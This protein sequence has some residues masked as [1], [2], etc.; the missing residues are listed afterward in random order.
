MEVQ[1]PV[2]NYE[3]ADYWLDCLLLSDGLKASSVC[4]GCNTDTKMWLES[5]FEG[6]RAE[7]HVVNEQ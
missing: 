2:C 1:S 3:V 4:E 7:N 5:D 6:R